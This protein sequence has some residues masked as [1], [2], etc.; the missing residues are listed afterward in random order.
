MKRLL[1]PL[2]L[3]ACVAIFQSGCKTGA[4]I[5]VTGLRVELTGIERTA[6]G[7]TTVNWRVVNPNVA[8]YLIGHSSHK[9]FLNGTLVGTVAEKNAMAVP[10]QTNV[11]ATGGLVVAGAEAEKLLASLAR[12]G[13]A[14]YRVE[15]NV[16]VIIYGDTEEKGD[17]VTSGSVSVTTK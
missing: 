4:S 16:L 1:L 3:L 5:I 14:S 10:A 6:D 17:F 8:P 7:A 12:Q 2:C 15:S 13:P 11:N 9:I